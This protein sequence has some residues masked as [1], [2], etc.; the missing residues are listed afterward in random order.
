MYKSKF[1]NKKIVKS[2]W[3]LINNELIYKPYSRCRIK[4]NLNVFLNR[5]RYLCVKVMVRL[6]R[7]AYLAGISFRNQWIL[8]ILSNLFVRNLNRKLAYQDQI[9]KRANS[10][11]ISDDHNFITF[12]TPQCKQ[13]FKPLSFPSPTFFRFRYCIKKKGKVVEDTTL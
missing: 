5:V 12:I 9:V 4:L 13:T 6:T 8:F 2:Q 11:S 3:K 1:E 10:I 7:L